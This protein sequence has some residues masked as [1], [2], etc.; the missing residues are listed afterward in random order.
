MMSMFAASD[1]HPEGETT[2][3]ELSQEAQDLIVSAFMGEFDETGPPEIPDDVKEEI[4]N[5]ANP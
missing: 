3:S 1:H 2:F 4:R 5:W